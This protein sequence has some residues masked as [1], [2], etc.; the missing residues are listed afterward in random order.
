MQ[1]HKFISAIFAL[2][3]ALGLWAYT[4]VYVSP[5]TTMPISGI[6]VR[7]RTED[8]L[9]ARGL[10]MTA[11]MDQT[12]SIVVR[13]N[14]SDLVKLDSE[15][16]KATADL[17][18]ITAPGTWDVTYTISYPDTVA[19]GDIVVESR[20][21][22]TVR[23]EVSLASVKTLKPSLVITGEPMEGYLLDSKNVVC[24]VDSVTITGPSYEV[25]N[26][27]SMQVNVDIT[28]MSNTGN[29]TCTYQLLDEEDNPVELSDLCTV[30]VTRKEG[31][32]GTGKEVIVTLPI[33]QYKEVRLEALYENMPAGAVVEDCELFP[34]TIVV[35]GDSKSLSAL[36]NVVK[37]SVD[38]AGVELPP[39]NQTQEYEISCVISLSKGLVVYASLDDTFDGVNVKA[40][41]T[42]R[43]VPAT[44]A[45]SNTDSEDNTAS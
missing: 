1:K 11:G 3:I 21:T 44:T 4:V 31:S 25:E 42:I 8:V 20:S 45:A 43:T 27:E 13:G 15:N 41:V 29:V 30:T 18:N 16:V 23:V 6:P 19:N 40:T 7:F 24:D 9:Q 39:E 2:L 26:I 22:S 36:G 28:D 10:I 38:L 35:T 14:R 12:I 17:S 5:E 33:L 34:E 37:I 32:E